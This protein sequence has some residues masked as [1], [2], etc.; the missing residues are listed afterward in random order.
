MGLA[1]SDFSQ[2]SA[3]GKLPF[4]SAGNQ[5]KHSLKL[6]R[7]L[8]RFFIV[9]MNGPVESAVRVSRTLFVE[10]PPASEEA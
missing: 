7:H 3:L 1:G 9:T 2:R 5:Q 10:M 8:D 4:L 6:F